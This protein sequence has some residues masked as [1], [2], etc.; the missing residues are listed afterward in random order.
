MIKRKNDDLDLLKKKRPESWKS[1]T[2]ENLFVSETGGAKKFVRLMKLKTDTPQ[3][4]WKIY[5]YLNTENLVLIMK[6][7]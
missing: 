5:K 7:Y 2:K 1:E 6:F 4:F 3:K